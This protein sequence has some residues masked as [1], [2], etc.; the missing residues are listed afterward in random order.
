MVK[1]IVQQNKNC[2]YNAEYFKTRTEEDKWHKNER[3]EKKYILNLI[4]Q[5]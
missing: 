5:N 2:N 1:T 3:V 4:L